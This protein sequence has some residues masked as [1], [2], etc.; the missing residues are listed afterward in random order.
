MNIQELKSQSTLRLFL[1][2]VITYAVYPVHYLR[3][4]TNLIN[5]QLVPPDRISHGF[6]VAN[7]AFAYLSLVL[8]VPYIV[9]PEGH[10][11]EIIS[12]VIDMISLILILVWSFKV[13]NRLNS[14]L[15]SKPGDPSWFHAG[16]TVFLE[17]LYINHKINVLSKREAGQGPR[18]DGEDAAAGPH[19]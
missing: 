4:L 15:G 13:R 9:V 6:I 8:L 2:T 14:A 11:L 10:P 17:Y 3:R 16:W 19:R 18:T 7:F 5:V 1:L 12:E